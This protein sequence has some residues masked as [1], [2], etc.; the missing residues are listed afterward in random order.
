MASYFGPLESFIPLEPLKNARGLHTSDCIRIILTEARLDDGDQTSDDEGSLVENQLYPA[1]HNA[2]RSSCM[3]NTCWE[4]KWDH[5]DDCVSAL[6][7][8]N[9]LLDKSRRT[10]FNF[11][12]LRR[13]PHLTVTWAHQSASSDDQRSISAHRHIE[14]NAIQGIVSGQDLNKSS[15][16]RNLRTARPDS[17]A[18]LVGCDTTHRTKYAL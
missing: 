16:T 1:P 3:D 18:S 2:P 9:L 14:H 6:M 4:I 10:N 11:Q 5:R 7:V 13:V 17:C 15:E 8:K 12:T